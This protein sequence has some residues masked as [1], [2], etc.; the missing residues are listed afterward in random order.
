MIRVGSVA[1]QA[2]RLA[3][4]IRGTVDRIAGFRR[5]VIHLDRRSETAESNEAV[6]G[7]LARR[8]PSLL[9]GLDAAARGAV[10]REWKGARSTL[11]NLTYHAGIGLALELSRRLRSG[12]YVTNSA[13][14]AAW[15]RREGRSTTPGVSTGQLVVAL[16]NARITVE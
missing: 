16:D 12:E 13:P 2:S 7:N 3:A 8:N 14:Y 5:A 10:S 1:S 15:K 6:L 4:T 11:E 9:R